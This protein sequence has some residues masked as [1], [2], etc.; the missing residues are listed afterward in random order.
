MIGVVGVPHGGLDIAQMFWDNKGIHGGIAPVRAYLELLLEMVLQ[1]HINPGLVWSLTWN[2]RSVRSPRPTR[3][4][5]SAARPR[6][7][8]VPDQ[9]TNSNLLGIE[10]L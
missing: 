1:R 6:S 8:C 9:G 5:M 10:R 3:R 7:C 2:S 4:W